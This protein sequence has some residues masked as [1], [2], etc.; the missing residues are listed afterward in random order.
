MSDRPIVQSHDVAGRAVAPDGTSG[1]PLGNLPLHHARMGRATAITFGETG[2]SW[3]SLEASANRRARLLAGLGVS[4]GDL[5]TVAL[6]NSLEFYE[7]TFALW[8]L[9]ATPNIVSSKLPDHELGAIVALVDPRLVLGPDPSRLPGRRVVPAGAPVDQDLSAESLPEV[10]APYWKAMT[11]GGSTG[12]PK[13]IVDHAPGLFDPGA[14]ALLQQVG[15]VILNPG[16]LYHNAPF[17]GTHWGL[18]VGGHVVEM[19]RFDASEALRA[20]SR[21]KVQWVNLVPTMMNRIWRLPLEERQAADLSS[22]RVMFHM[23]SSCPAWLKEA[24]IEWLGPERVFELY[25]GTER[26][27]ATVISGVEWL[28]HK[29]SVGRVQAGSSVRVLRDDGSPCAPGEVG[30]IY[31]LPDEGRNATYHYIG[32]EAKVSGDWE[33]LGD[34]GH[35]DGD[36]YLYISDRRLDLIVS[37]G[38]NVYPAEVE[39]AIEAHSEVR[40]A[41]VIGRPHEDLGQEVHAIVE[42]TAGSSLT[43]EAL[44]RFVAERLVRYKTP[45]SLE[46]VNHPLRDDAGKVRRGAFHADIN[47][48]PAKPGVK[49]A[50]T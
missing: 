27:G 46:F 45:R 44:L 11:S 37:G 38:A 6:P 16:P 15:D 24:W 17:I 4:R 22:L 26:Q 32:A 50:F 47:G 36:G 29:G 14:P 21:H 19:G 35:L 33:S 7:T 5:I 23:A 42:R 41:V 1:I 18:F 9:G 20:L 40:S 48:A 10:I 2:M 13:V 30:E 31:F 12:R 39:A 3:A 43:E 34:L 49:D 28:K 8:K 25:G